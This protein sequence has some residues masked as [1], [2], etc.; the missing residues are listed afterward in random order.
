[1]GML[2]TRSIFEEVFRLATPIVDMGFPPHG[3]N[4][5][6]KTSSHWFDCVMVFSWKD[7]A[8]THL[9][10]P[11]KHLS[12]SPDTSEYVKALSQNTWQKKS[13][14]RLTSVR[15]CCWPSSSSSWDQPRGHSNTP[16]QKGFRIFFKLAADGTMTLLSHIDDGITK[17][18]RIQ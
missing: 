7:N 17:A 18:L 9:Q 16:S 2:H 4:T 1:M 15:S 14:P 8:A 11:N 5:Q 13:A 6:G 10:H 3:F 12:L